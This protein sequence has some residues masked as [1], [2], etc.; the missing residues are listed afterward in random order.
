MAIKKEFG[1]PCFCAVVLFKVNV[2]LFEEK[3]M[4][5]VVNLIKVFALRFLGL[6]CRVVVV[7]ELL[8]NFFHFLIVLSALCEI[9]LLIVIIFHEYINI[10]Q[11][12]R[13]FVY[14]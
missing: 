12:G 5:V 3:R 2:V 7:N 9:L 11:L 6:S 13:A 8:P 4:Q 14:R 1:K 10:N